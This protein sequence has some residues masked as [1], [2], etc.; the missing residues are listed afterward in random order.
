MS[1]TSGRLELFSQL[2]VEPIALVNWVRLPW[3]DFTSTVVSGR[4]IYSLTPRMFVSA[5]VQDNSS[6]KTLSIN[7]RFRWEYQP[8]SELFVVYSDGRDTASQG[9][10]T[11]MNRTFVVKINR[12]FQF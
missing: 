4:I 7:A 3:G 11:L 1:F 10:P 5:L 2:A 8:R 6:T 12:L 9:L